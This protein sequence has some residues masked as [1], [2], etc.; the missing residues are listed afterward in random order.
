MTKIGGCAPSG[1]DLRHFGADRE[2]PRDQTP[3]RGAKQQKP[4][5]SMLRRSAPPEPPYPMYFLRPIF[6]GLEAPRPGMAGGRVCARP[7]GHQPG[8]LLRN[9]TTNKG[10]DTPNRRTAT[11]WGGRAGAQRNGAKKGGWNSAR[12]SGWARQAGIASIS[13]N[14]L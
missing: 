1:A 9:H 4:T 7:G 12:L 11:N 13:A 8:D 2:G 14:F 6:A 3:G 5:A 10:T